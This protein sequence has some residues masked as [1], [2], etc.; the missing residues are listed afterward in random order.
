[1]AGAEKQ[2]IALANALGLPYD[3]HPALPRSA[4]LQRLPT[5]LLCAA[6]SRLGSRALCITLPAPPHP[7]VAIS[8]GRGSIPASVALRAESEYRTF[9]VHV[10]KPTCSESWFDLVVAPDHDYVRARPPANVLLSEGSLHDVT[11]TSL[12][13]AR[14]EWQPALEPLPSPRLALL[15]GGS[16]SRRYAPPRVPRA[17]V[18][19]TPTS[20]ARLTEGPG[21]LHVLTG[22]GS[23]RSRPTSP[24]RQRLSWCALP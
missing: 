22:C 2:A 8:C 3:V 5:P 14:G 1:M 10:Q 16:M 17:V 4:W 11:P 21:A 7:I 23:S 9:T 18:R 20:F 24:P 12:A 19:A 15:L 6:A 13:D